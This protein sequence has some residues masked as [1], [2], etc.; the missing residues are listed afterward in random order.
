MAAVESFCMTDRPQTYLVFAQGAGCPDGKTSER[1]HG[2]R[3]TRPRSGP[4]AHAAL[5][6][7]VA[8]SLPGSLHG[9]LHREPYRGAYRGCRWKRSVS[10]RDRGRGCDALPSTDLTPRGSL[11]GR[12]SARRSRCDRPSLLV[13]GR[14]RGVGKTTAL[15]A[16]N[17]A[18]R[19][20]GMA[21]YQ[22]AI[23]GRAA[24]RI[25]EATGQHAQ[26]VA[27]WLKGVADGRIELGRH[28]IVIID[29]ASMLDLPTLYR[30]LFHLPKEARC[31]LVGDTAQLPP[32]GFGLTLHRLVKEKR[33]PKT[34]L[35]RIL[36]ATESTGI[37]QVSVA[38]RGGVLPDLPSYSS[39]RGGC[40]LIHATGTRSSTRS[41]MFCTTFVGGKFRS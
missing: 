15:K 23:A 11:T 22:L 6:L 20:F 7:T 13:V 17:A 12:V 37:P 18:A 30:I 9:T 10:R 29:E 21:V 32:I 31:L 19:N 33:I 26:T 24:K 5:R 40:S 35:T 27:S 1:Q 28:T 36:R 34:E 38:I 16:V 3:R 41:R 25:A 4:W 39:R 2:K 14:W 8:I